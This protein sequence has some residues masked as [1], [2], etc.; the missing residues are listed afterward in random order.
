[1]IANPRDLLSPAPM[2]PSDATRRDNVLGKYRRG[3]VTSSAKD[4]QATGNIK[5][6]VN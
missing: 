1:M 5:A 6:A 4:E 3:E 2:D